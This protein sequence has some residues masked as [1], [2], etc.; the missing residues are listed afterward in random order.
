MLSAQKANRILGC[1]KRSVASREGGDPAPLLCAGEILLGVL[2]PDVESSVH[3]R[4]RPGRDTD[5]LEHIQSRATK[6]IQG[7]PRLQR[8]A[9]RAGTVQPGEEEAPRRPHSSLQYLK[10][11]YKKE[12]DRPFIRVCCDR[13]RGNCFKLKEGNLDM[14]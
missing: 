12:E 5:L 9:V 1:I 11:H 7:T 2:C 10:G 6:M 3:E 8:Q 13:T 4:H 14:T